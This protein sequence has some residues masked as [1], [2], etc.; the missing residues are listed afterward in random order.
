MA[1]RGYLPGMR[2]GR[3][4]HYACRKVDMV[5]ECEE[6]GGSGCLSP[7]MAGNSA[8]RSG[9]TQIGWA[10]A[11]RDGRVAPLSPSNTS[12]SHETGW[13]S[14]SDRLLKR[15]YVL[16]AFAAATPPAV[17]LIQGPRVGG[18]HTCLFSPRTSHKGRAST[19]RQGESISGRLHTPH[20]KAI[21]PRPRFTRTPA[22]SSPLLF[23]TTTATPLV[24][25]IRM[26]PS[27]G[28][29]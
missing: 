17:G 19:R 15:R 8:T 12:S 13:F 1:E 5:D 16:I 9:S 7:E 24:L 22:Q 4:R 23:T 11:R 28:S 21:S 20:E 2:G 3:R 10:V 14:F 18:H 25:L 29:S 6:G 26:N 27:Q